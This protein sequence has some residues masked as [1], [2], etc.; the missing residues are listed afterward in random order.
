MSDTT[1]QTGSVDPLSQLMGILERDDPSLAP[2]VETPDEAEAV[3]VEAEPEEVEEVEAQ[4]DDDDGE[5]AEI[6][7]DQAAEVDEADEGSEDDEPVYRVVVDGEPV[8]VPLSELQKGYSREAHFTRRMQQLAEER[9]QIEQ[10]QQQLE[11]EYQQRLDRLAELVPDEKEPDW[12]RLAQEDPLGYAEQ[13]AIWDARQKQ[14]EVVE[15]ERAEMARK[16]AEQQQ[17]HMQQYLHNEQQ[18]LMEKIPEFRDAKTAKAERDRI[19]NALRYA[20]FKDDELQQLYDH[21]AVVVGRLAAIGL[22]TLNAKSLETKKAAKPVKALKPS[23]APKQGKADKEK[24]ILRKMAKASSKQQHDD[25]AVQLL[26][27]RIDGG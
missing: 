16:Q 10:R 13:R 5:E 4:S 11:Q 15:R 20:G 19:A 26:M 12:V 17:R 27:G 8:E 18:M 2:P 1:P 23:T 22:E 6:V 3:E 25:L 24:D 21:R 7:E 14:R 9:R